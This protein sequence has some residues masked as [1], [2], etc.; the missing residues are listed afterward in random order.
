M[1]E[2]SFGLLLRDDL[3]HA[4]DRLEWSLYFKVSTFAI[5]LM[6]QN[7]CADRSIYFVVTDIRL[8]VTSPSILHN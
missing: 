2:A 3:H 1:F 4:F 6:S 7:P 5:R 8:A